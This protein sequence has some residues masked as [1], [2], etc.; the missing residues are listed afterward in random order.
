MLTTANRGHQGTTE[1]NRCQKKQTGAN[2]EQM[3]PTGDNR[4]QL[5]PAEAYSRGT[6]GGFIFGHTENTQTWYGLA[7]FNEAKPK[8]QQAQNLC[9]AVYIKLF[10]NKGQK[11]SKLIQMSPNWH[12]IYK[13]VNKGPT[14]GTNRIQK[15]PTEANKG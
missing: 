10:L 14:G 3:R 6:P 12:T 1:A 2:M 13:M 8:D 15:E 4:V 9:I 5:R 7:K 11:G